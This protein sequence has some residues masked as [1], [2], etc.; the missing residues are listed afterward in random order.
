[1][2]MYLA[3]DAEYVP[4]VTATR[5]VVELDPIG[6]SVRVVPV[7]LYPVAEA[8]YGYGVVVA[9]VRV[10]DVK[11]TVFAAT[12]AIEA[13][14][15]MVSAVAS[16]TLTY[17]Q[18]VEAPNDAAERLYAPADAL[19]AA[20]LTLAMRPSPD[21]VRVT[22]SPVAGTAMLPAESVVQTL[23]SAPLAPPLAKVP[24]PTVDT[25]RFE[26]PELTMTEKTL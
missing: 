17:A 1:M 9:A 21:G 26:T 15:L 22:V 14:T 3:V 5:N 7:F 24:P 20:P 11:E 8:L 6:N 23:M 16:V 12:P 2:P 10:R 13:T 25:V 4:A 19:V 18:P